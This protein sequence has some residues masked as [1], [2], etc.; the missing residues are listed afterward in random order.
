MKRKE[1][2]IIFSIG[3]LGLFLYVGVCKIIGY[4][5]LIA[6]EDV[7]YVKPIRTG[8]EGDFLPS[9]ELLLADSM[10]YIST[11]SISNEKPVVLFYLGPYCPYC[12]LEVSEIIKN[13][14]SLD[15]IQFYL[16]T[17]YSLSDMRVFCKRN[18]LEK[19][20]N[21]VVGMDYKF[22][23]A[24]YFKAQSIPYLAIYGDD[25]KLRAAFVGVI[26]YEQLRDI[27]RK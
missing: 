6:K 8:H 12:Q 7:Q 1:I 26:K 15:D 4:P 25:Q 2:F 16:I 24:D 17:P 10:S 22:K 18:N 11:A 19:Y 13:M 21:I 3:V 14:K 27:L 20:A 9:I 5:L 23:F